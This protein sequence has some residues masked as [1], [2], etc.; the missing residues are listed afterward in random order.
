VNIFIG[1]IVVI[2]MITPIVY[3]TNVWESQKLPII[4]NRVFD[5]NGNFY[6][7]T[8]VLDK[9]LQ[10]NESAYE[11]YGNIQCIY[12]MTNKFNHCR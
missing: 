11:I 10:L 5:I 8:K 4:S 3:Y 9:N 6:N 2:W 12:C 7:I 1:F